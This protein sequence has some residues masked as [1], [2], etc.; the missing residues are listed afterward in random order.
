[1]LTKLVI[2]KTCNYKVG[3]TGVTPGGE[4]LKIRISDKKR[5]S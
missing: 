1:M 2:G 5:I 3:L 4:K